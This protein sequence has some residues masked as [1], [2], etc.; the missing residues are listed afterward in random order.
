MTNKI[1]VIDIE[2]SPALAYVW[3]LWDQ[4]I[5]LKQL[6]RPSAPISFAAKWFGSK[7]MS[8]HSDWIDGHREMI[9][10]AHEL[11]SE[12]DAVVGYN[13]DS[14]DLK[15]LRG[16]F[17]LAGLPPPPTITSIDLL[18]SVK[19]LGL[20]SGKLDYVSQLL[21][22][23]KKVPHEGFELWS[24]VLDGDPKAQLR[25]E[26]YNIGDVLLTEK[27]YAKLR[28]YIHNHPHLGE[29]GSTACGA[30]GS[31]KTQSRGF[32]RTKAFKVQRIQCMTCGSWSTGKR[33]KVG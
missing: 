13:S 26:K 16:E 22:L 8:F 3:G 9:V 18:K 11:L 10:K 25:M 5:S 33:T 6:I 27:L 15:K 23:G 19:K 32:Y 14:F 17:L 21:N 31:K 29:T 24:K 7:E 1:L 30:C 20:Q 28:P 12:A 4:N 2:T